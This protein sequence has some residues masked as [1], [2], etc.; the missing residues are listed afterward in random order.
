MQRRT[1]L[2][3]FVGGSALT[4]F[5]KNKVLGGLKPDDYVTIMSKDVTTFEYKW[6]H[7]G[8]DIGVRFGAAQNFSV[9]RAQRHMKAQ[10][11][12]DH[13]VKT[14]LKMAEE[15]PY[16][17][18]FIRPLVRSLVTKANQMGIDPIELMLSFVQGIPY[19]DRQSYQS[20]PTETLLD[21]EGDCSDTAVAFAALVENYQAWNVSRVG[22]KPLWCFLRS[23]GHLAVGVRR[24][25]GSA[26]Y[27]G[28]YWDID[29]D[30]YFFCETTGTGFRIGDATV[31]RATHYS[32]RP[33]V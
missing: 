33:F 28:S 6:R 21:V 13:G 11:C 19:Q 22:G 14:Y 32:P 29:G 18:Q 10:L 3:A 20:W 31:D 23:P 4:T 1:L 24:H 9:S 26:W 27:V 7:L 15:D 5:A 30:P 25:V 2:V 16:R 12:H 17:V 8:R